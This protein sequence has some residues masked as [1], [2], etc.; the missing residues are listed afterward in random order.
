M[1]QLMPSVLGVQR[2][3][4]Q[5]EQTDRQTDRTGCEGIERGS[6]IHGFKHAREVNG[7]GQSSLLSLFIRTLRYLHNPAMCILSIEGQIR[8]HDVLSPI[9]LPVEFLRHEIRVQRVRVFRGRFLATFA[10]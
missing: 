5:L 2:F 6:D 4:L 10:R 8:P 1:V 3:Q 9:L 7:E